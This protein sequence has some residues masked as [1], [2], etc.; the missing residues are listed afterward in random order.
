MVCTKLTYE[1]GAHYIKGCLFLPTEMAISVNKIE[2][3]RE[4]RGWRT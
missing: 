1:A 3:R 4:K 2:S